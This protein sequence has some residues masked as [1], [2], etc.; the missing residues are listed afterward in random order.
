MHARASLASGI[1]ALTNG[2]QARGAAHPAHAR[3]RAR[4]PAREPRLAATL[5]GRPARGTAQRA[6]W[7]QTARNTSAR[8]YSDP[9]LNRHLRSG[10]NTARHA[11]G[12]APHAQPHARRVG[13]AHAHAGRDARLRGQRHPQAHRA[14]RA[15]RHGRGH[16]CQGKRRVRHA[17]RR[18][19]QRPHA[20]LP[21]RARAARTTS[22]AGRAPGRRLQQD[23]VRRGRARGHPL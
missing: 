12:P 19:L 4:A 3:G 13:H 14:R 15:R 8:R 5:L 16:G 9:L 17:L 6:N 7:K 23:A 18:P 1:L 22:R 20:P 2:A 21:W 11:R 10:R